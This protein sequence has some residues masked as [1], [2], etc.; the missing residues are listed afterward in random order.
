MPYYRCPACTLTVHSVAGRLR[1]NL[2]PNCGAPLAAGDRIEIHE[3]HP[4]A[5]TR[6]FASEPG[7][8][9]VARHELEH[10]LWALD[11]AEFQV[12]SL[13]VTELIANSV[14]HANGDGGV[15]LDVV[16]TDELVHVEV[17]D[18]GTGFE[19]HERDP[20]LP[21]EPH[22]GLHLVGSLTDRWGFDATPTTRVWF[23]F[24]RVPTSGGRAQLATAARQLNC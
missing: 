22:W 11:P 20:D 4:A 23:E 6:S 7:A 13:L 5:I 21:L 15:R 9:A 8:A 18:T 24:D 19:P 14:Q 2:C 16:L 17:R 3:H 10:L 1:A 12:L